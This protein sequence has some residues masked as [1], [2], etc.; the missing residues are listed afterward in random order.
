MDFESTLRT[1]AL[2]FP[3]PAQAEDFVRENSR[4]GLS[5]IRV[6]TDAEYT[7]RKA[8]L[9]DGLG[10]GRFDL[11]HIEPRSRLS[12]A[13]EYIA[14]AE[15]LNQ[16]LLFVGDG[17]N[18]EMLA[19]LAIWLRHI[20]DDFPP[21]CASMLVTPLLLA[22]RAPACSLSNAHCPKSCRHERLLSE[23]TAAR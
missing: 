1:G 23:K 4:L 6:R 14:A 11:S 12:R 5:A 2:A 21:G 18:P 16:H 13:R 22:K 9:E 19:V 15:D 10:R 20:D 7:A 17:R 3:T 8:A